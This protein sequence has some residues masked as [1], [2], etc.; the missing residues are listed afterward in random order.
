M[1]IGLLFV[2]YVRVQSD[3][4]GESRPSPLVCLTSQSN[5]LRRIMKT[6]LMGAL[7]AGLLGEADTTIIVWS[8]SCL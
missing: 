2:A 3:D 5:I 4:L 8:N 7:C 6:R 1:C